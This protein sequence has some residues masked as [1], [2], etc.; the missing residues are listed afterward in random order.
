MFLF[1]EGMM[2]KMS[3]LIFTYNLNLFW[4]FN[5]CT[6]AAELCLW[7]SLPLHVTSLRFFFTSLS[8]FIIIICLRTQAGTSGTNKITHKNKCSTGLL[9][10]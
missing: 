1:H 4:N 7:N 9:S 6:A 10:S 8:I 3:A 5:A 2:M